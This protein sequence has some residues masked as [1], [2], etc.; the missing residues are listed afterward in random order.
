MV[1]PRTSFTDNLV[2]N[3]TVPQTELRR[4]VMLLKNFGT[5]SKMSGHRRVPL[6][7]LRQRFIRLKQ[8]RIHTGNR[9]HNVEQGGTAAHRLS[10]P[11]TGLDHVIGDVRPAASDKNPFKA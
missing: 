9:R 8:S 3:H 7:K 5:V 1:I 6:E 2:G 10:N 4:H 11:R